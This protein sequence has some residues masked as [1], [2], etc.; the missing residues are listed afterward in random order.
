MLQSELKSKLNP[1]WASRTWFQLNILLNMKCN[2]VIVIIYYEKIKLGKKKKN[3]IVSYLDQ[4]FQQNPFETEVF[5]FSK[6]STRLFQSFFIKN[7]GF[8]WNSHLWTSL[9]TGAMHK[10]EERPVKITADANNNNNHYYC[11]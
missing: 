9:E 10:H 7:K 2:L 11:Y 3:K 5:V 1:G 8:S 6:A 4:S